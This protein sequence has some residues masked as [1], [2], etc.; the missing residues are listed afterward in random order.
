MRYRNSTFYFMT[1]KKT[2]SKYLNKVVHAHGG[3]QGTFHQQKA[4]VLGFDVKQKST[5]Y[6][7]S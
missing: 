7:S 5:L 1:E 6:R 3:C 2:N 4:R